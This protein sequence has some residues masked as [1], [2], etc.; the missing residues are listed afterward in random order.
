MCEITKTVNNH[1]YEKHSLLAIVKFERKKKITLEGH[2]M[3]RCLRQDGDFQRSQKYEAK[4][5]MLYRIIS[6]QSSTVSKI[7]LCKNI[8]SNISW[9]FEPIGEEIFVW[10]LVLRTQKFLIWTA[11][12][13]KAKTVL[14]PIAKEMSE[15][16]E[17][18]V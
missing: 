16:A 7:M 17:F 18:V 5:I 3:P 8:L 11:Y 15:G 14:C 2:V 4:Y 10:G 1:Y 9:N 12:E 6:R 13:S